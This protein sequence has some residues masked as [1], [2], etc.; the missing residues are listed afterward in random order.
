MFVDIKRQRSNT[1]TSN[2]TYRNAQHTKNVHVYFFKLSKLKAVV[3]LVASVSRPPTTAKP[4]SGDEP[5]ATNT[6]M[7]KV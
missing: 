4:L 5:N 7:I 1:N 6:N 2:N 3:G